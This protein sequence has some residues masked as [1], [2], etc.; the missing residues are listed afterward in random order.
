MVGKRRPHGSAFKAK[1][2]LVAIRGEKTLAE[3]A[4]KFGIDPVQVSDW[5]MRLL[6]GAGTSSRMAVARV[7]RHPRTKRS[8]SSRLAA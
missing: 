2:A 5:K 8:C 1:A 4:F 7:H 3:V 6:E